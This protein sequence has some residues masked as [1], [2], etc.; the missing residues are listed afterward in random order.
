MVL[1]TG[2]M[3]LLKPVLVL[4]F[5]P[6]LTASLTT[7]FGLE[8]F[9]IASKK[10]QIS[11]RIEPVRVNCSE[12][13][14]ADALGRWKEANN[15]WKWKTLTATEHL[16]SPRIKNETCQAVLQQFGHRGK[17]EYD[18]CWQGE[19]ERE[20]HRGR[21]RMKVQRKVT[22]PVLLYCLMWDLLRLIQPI[23]FPNS[24]R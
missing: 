21:T 17:L 4:I 19:R 18:W 12:E 10:R 6:C 24:R 13:H 14:A 20:V 11:S 22:R 2:N 7:E 23:S 9:A 3:L 16:K 15:S 5:H 8:Y 1:I